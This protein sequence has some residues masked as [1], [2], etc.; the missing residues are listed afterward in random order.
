MNS[1]PVSV[2]A[3][4]L[5]QGFKVIERSD[6]DSA[7]G[8]HP[9]KLL[10]STNKE[11]I[12]QVSTAFPSYMAWESSSM[13]AVLELPFPFQ[14]CLHL[15]MGS[16]TAANPTTNAQNSTLNEFQGGASSSIVCIV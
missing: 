2:P 10:P 16:Q 8:S 12:Q 11:P 9:G 5:P 7:L 1:W 14:P 4:C 6:G 13:Q 3:Q 15:C